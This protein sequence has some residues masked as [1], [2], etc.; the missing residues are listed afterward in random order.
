MLTDLE[1]VFHSLKSEL[2]L[3]PV[4]NQL[5]KCV[6]THLFITVLTYHLIHTIRVKLRTEKITY[7]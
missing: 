4:H 7:S 2:G 3:R 1:V 5:A 6:S